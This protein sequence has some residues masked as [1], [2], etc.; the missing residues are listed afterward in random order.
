MR[1]QRDGGDGLPVPREPAEPVET[2]EPGR[3]ADWVPQTPAERAAA[4][5]RLDRL[6]DRWW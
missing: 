2:A 5:R 1:R 6:A 4:R 3:E